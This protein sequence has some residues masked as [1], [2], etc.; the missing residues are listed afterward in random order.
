MTR[1]QPKPPAELGDPVF[2]NVAH[3]PRHSFYWH[4]HGFPSPLAQWNFHPEYELHLIRHSRGHYMVGDH[5]GRFGPGNL[6]LVGPNLPHVWFSDLDHADQ[7]IE[8]RDVV[9]Q[10]RGEWLESLMRL[11]PELR[12]VET[13]IQDSER[14]VLFTGLEADT[15]AHRLEAMGGQDELVRVSTL[16]E[17]LGRLTRSDYHVLA[18]PNYHLRRTG[19]HSGQVDAILVYIHRHFNRH[20]SMTAMARWQGMTPSTFSRFFKQATGD[21]FVAFV[22]RLRIDQACRLLLDPRYSVAD[23]CF[24]TGYSNL[25]NFNRHFRRL[26]GMTPREYRQSSAAE[27]AHGTR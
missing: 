11:C 23:I 9:V 15:A 27:S 22:R 21:T 18:S 12:R 3:D 7:V 6:V 1:R 13:L 14:G 16:I 17:L 8:R 24:M 5:A 25:S 2:E 20:I 10:F 26:T 4:T 19:V